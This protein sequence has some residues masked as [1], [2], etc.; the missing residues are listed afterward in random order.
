LLAVVHTLVGAIEL[1]LTTRMT[2]G[3]RRYV[4][5]CKRSAEHLTELC[6][7][8]PSP[9][10]ERSFERLAID[11][12]S[13]LGVSYVPKPV[14]RA[15]LLDAVKSIDDRHRLRILAADD[16]ADTCALIGQF[17]KGTA[18]RLDFVHDGVSAVEKYQRAK[19][20][21][22]LLLIDLDMPVMDGRTAIRAIRGWETEHDRRHAPVMVLTAHDLIARPGGAAHED[23]EG[24]NLEGLNQEEIVVDPDPEIAH[25]VPGFLAGRRHDVQTVL[26]ALTDSDYDAI[27]RVGHMLKGTGGA[28]GFDGIS[29]IGSRLEE[30][31]ERQDFD[32]IRET[33]AALDSYLAHV[34]L[35]GAS[36]TTSQS[37]SRH[38]RT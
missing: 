12:L 29:E 8:L 26:H 10:S 24:A 6:R 20:R 4:N 35:G 21:Y 1:L 30:G 38:D 34:R 14:S 16:S 33:V 28:Y 11:D 31:A 32:Q 5:V 17:L 15:Q 22:D 37:S 7:Q 2:A 36:G 13:E 27:R 19:G 23:P 9:L 3:Q 18:G 25:L